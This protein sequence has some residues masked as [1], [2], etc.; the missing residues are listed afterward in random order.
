MISVLAISTLVPP[1]LPTDSFKNK[2]QPFFVLLLFHQQISTIGTVISKTKNVFIISL[3]YTKTSKQNSMKAFKPV[4]LFAL[5][6][7]S[8]ASCKKELDSPGPGEPQTPVTELVQYTNGDEYVKFNYAAG[9]SIS[10]IILK[11]EL[12]TG[13]EEESYEVAYAD[14]KIAS[15]TSDDHRIVAV[16]EG[17]ALKRADMFEEEERVSYT[18]Y[19][20]YNGK[21]RD[22]TLYSSYDGAFS[23]VF[24]YR[25]EYDGDE[26]PSEL[27]A[28]IAGDRPN[29]LVRAGSINMQYDEKVNPLYKH[30]DLLLLLWKPV[31]KNNITAED[32]FDAEL[33]PE[34]KYMYT[35]NY[36]NNGL[37]KSAEVKKGLPGQ[38]SETFGINYLYQ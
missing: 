25:L 36:F 2:Q 1:V 4:Y 15:L 18:N 10:G 5:A 16:Y 17:G 23:P 27:I 11:T 3:M 28:L 26:N 30:K 32:H 13:N 24:S 6:L 14:G 22:I 21:L 8:L 38:P 12:M 35:Y 9:N 7:L 34:D 37:P 33:K 29:L 19:D 31:T 20:Y